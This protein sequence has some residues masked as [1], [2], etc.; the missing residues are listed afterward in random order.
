MKRKANQ[1]PIAEGLIGRKS[2]RSNQWPHPACANG[3]SVGFFTGERRRYPDVW[4]RKRYQTRSSRDREAQPLEKSLKP[5]KALH[6]ASDLILAACNWPGARLL[7]TPV[8]LLVSRD[9]RQPSGVD[10]KARAT[11]AKWR[12]SEREA[13]PFQEIQDFQDNEYVR[14]NG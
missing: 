9:G 8:R 12:E 14:P 5:V 1:P 7:S 10:A 13:E 11:G 3:A 2:T 6:W 4:N